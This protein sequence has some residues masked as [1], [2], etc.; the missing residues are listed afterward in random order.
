MKK[1]KKNAIFDNSHKSCRLVTCARGSA[2]CIS[3]KRYWMGVACEWFASV[4]RHKTRKRLIKRGCCP[5][6]HSVIWLYVHQRALT[7]WAAHCNTRSVH[8]LLGLLGLQ[9][10]TT[11]RESLSNRSARG[12]RTFVRR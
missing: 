4:T 5:T 1:R 2:A 6:L 8:N 10:T 12:G 7:V 3:L 11:A 9:T